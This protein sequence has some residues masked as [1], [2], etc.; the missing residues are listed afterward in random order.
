ME[1]Y[2]LQIHANA[3]N[4]NLKYLLYSLTFLADQ[5]R[6]HQ[7][8]NDREGLDILAQDLLSFLNT[9]ELFDQVRL[10]DIRGMEVARANYNDGNPTL[11]QQDKLQWKGDRYYFRESIKL[12]KGE[13]YISPLDLNVEY[14]Q[15][16][17]P[18]KPVIRFAMPV[19]DQQ[20]HK[21]GIIIMNYL[22][23]NMLRQFRKADASTEA[24]IMLLNSDGYWL[25]APEP[26]MEWGFMFPERKKQN[27][28]EINPDVWHRILQSENGQFYD[29]NGTLFTFTTVYPFGSGLHI[30]FVHI[31]E[32]YKR[33]FWKL[34]SR[35][36]ESLV[37][38][39][40]RSNH[41]FYLQWFTGM[42]LA[43]VAVCALLAGSIEHRRLATEAFEEKLQQQAMT[44]SLTGVNNRW[45]FIK[46]ASLELSRARRHRQ[47]L[48]AL[49]LDIDHFKKINDTH[50]HA[51]GDKVLKET[52]RTCKEEL[53]DIDMFCRWGGE[54]FVAFLPMTTGKQGVE[55]AERIRLAIERL[56]VTNNQTISPTISIGVAE[57]DEKDDIDSLVARADAAM[58]KAKKGG[59]N[60]VEFL[61]KT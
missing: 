10:L 4:D 23:E 28:G 13:I 52:S 8:F 47:P 30:P 12:G 43:I 55:V 46:Q 34:V 31:R 44:D 9:T 14:G 60:C 41:G 27:F 21:V 3:L 50:G 5:V 6:L 40:M 20:D 7:P 48:T 33:Y 54:E 57:L 1:K 37:P 19:F 15:V 39:S 16:E 61:G 17:R 22:A 32:D 35:Y 25:V 56:E 29:D 59:R 2:H 51:M 49:M 36:P 24:D 38:A 45:Y 11:S 42:A 26:A 53:R 18:F 58:Y